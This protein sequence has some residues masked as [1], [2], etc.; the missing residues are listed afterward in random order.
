MEL[1]NDLWFDIGTVGGIVVVIILAA[2]SI[3]LPMSAY[4]AQKWAYKTYLETRSVNQKLAKLLELAQAGTTLRQQPAAP[5]GKAGPKRREPT[6]G[7]A[8]I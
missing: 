2:L 6:I 7:N 4:A 1:L 3:L 8:D 5:A